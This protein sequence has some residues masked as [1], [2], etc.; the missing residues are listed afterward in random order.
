MKKLILSILAVLVAVSLLGCGETPTEATGENPTKDSQKESSTEN[1]TSEPDGI[2][3]VGYARVVMTPDYSVPLA[4]YGNVRTRMSDGYLDDICATCTAITDETGYTIIVFNFD[5]INIQSC[6]DGNV[7]KEL[8]EKVSEATGIPKEQILYNNS[9]TH[10]SVSCAE[11]N[12]DGSVEF[13]SDILNAAV[14]AA[15]EA[16]ADRKKATNLYFGTCDLTGFNFVKHYF[17]EFDESVGD[18]HGGYA[19]GTVN[20]HTTESNHTMYLL[21]FEREDAKDVLWTN[22]RGHPILTGGSSKTDISADVIYPMRWHLEE[23]EDVLFCYFQGE[24]GNNNFA[25]RLADEPNHGT[26]YLKWGLDASKLIEDALHNNMKAIGLGKVRTEGRVTTLQHNHTQDW[27]TGKAYPI[28]TYWK[29]SNDRNGIWQ[30]C[31]DEGIESPYHAGAIITN[32]QR[33]KEANDV[34]YHVVLI[35]DFAMTMGCFELFDTNGMWIR[36][37]SP[38]EYM[39]T[40][41]YSCDSRGYLPSQYGFEYGCY[42][43][44]TCAFAPGSGEVYAEA[45]LDL[46]KEMWS[47][48]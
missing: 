28:N 35:G 13:R 24:A 27:M 43:A 5:V 11:G 18:N 17:T 48:K 20:R 26:D 8:Y 40:C 46:L 23:D 31:W 12:S 37:N 30:M 3:S 25:T 33:P 45:E 1:R 21:R 38:S 32:S 2:F 9:H 19:K 10:S 42:E 14:K 22:F 34:Q 7:G 16:L 44:D 15:Q 36:E 29:E 4:G 6:Y 47:Q 41:G 39:F